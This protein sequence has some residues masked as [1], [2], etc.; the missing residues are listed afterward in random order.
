M[1]IHKFAQTRIIMLRDFLAISIR[2][3]NQLLYIEIYNS[4]NSNLKF[5]YFNRLEELAT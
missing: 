5:C 3:R 1:H 4:A 2:G